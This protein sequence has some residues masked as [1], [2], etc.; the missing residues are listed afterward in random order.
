[1][2]LFDISFA[3]LLCNSMKSSLFR[4]IQG[5]CCDTDQYKVTSLNSHLTYCMLLPLTQPL[6]WCRLSMGSHHFFLS[7]S[8]TQAKQAVA[9]S[10]HQPYP[11]YHQCL[12]AD[13]VGYQ[14]SCRPEISGRSFG[15]E[16]SP[17]KFCNSPQR[18]DPRTMVFSNED[19]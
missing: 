1:M 14:L 17:M 6:H 13:V 2:R 19:V 9:F 7:R 12:F 5:M 4:L 18:L 3:V 15:G 8:R 10:F 16:N 11:K